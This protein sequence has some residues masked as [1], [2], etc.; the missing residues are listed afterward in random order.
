M[1]GVGEN[2]TEVMLLGAPIEAEALV[3]PQR[4]DHLDERLDRSASNDDR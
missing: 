4:S 3:V 1:I 2:G